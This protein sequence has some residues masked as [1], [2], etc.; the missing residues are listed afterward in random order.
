MDF[1]LSLDNTKYGFG[2]ELTGELSERDKTQ[3][4]VFCKRRLMQV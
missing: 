3:P 2:G 1:E 4:T